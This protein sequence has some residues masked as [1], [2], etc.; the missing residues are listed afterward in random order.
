MGICSKM[1]PLSHPVL[2]LGERLKGSESQGQMCSWGWTQDI[3]HNII[4][5][6]HRRGD[7]AKQTAMYITGWGN[8]TGKAATHV[9]QGHPI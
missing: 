3:Q 7:M 5:H 6:T 8:T 9:L 4:I 2:G 1:T